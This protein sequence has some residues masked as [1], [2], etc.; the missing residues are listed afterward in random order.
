MLGINLGDRTMKNIALAG[1]ILA[2]IA[3]VLCAGEPPS[4]FE[5]IAHARSTKKVPF[6]VVDAATGKKQI[7]FKSAV[8]ELNRKVSIDPAKTAVVVCDMW[9]DHWCKAAAARCD[10]LAK[11]AD[12]V[13]KACRD[14][15]MTIIH[16]P[17]DCTG[18]YKDH[19]AR[20]RM[21]MVPKTDP[22]QAREL[23]NPPLPVDDSDGGCDDE[24]PAKQ[25][26]AWSRQNAAIAI[27]EDKDYITD[28]GSEVYSLLASRKLGTLLV[29][30]VHTN[31]CVL[32]RTF[33]IKQM[34]KWGQEVYLVRDLTD[35]MYNPKMK[36]FVDHKK[37]TELIIEFI[38]LNWCPTIE[39]K[40]LVGGK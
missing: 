9:D 24:K 39:S 2:A 33:A 20:K 4:K 7:E 14:K 8:E 26:R 36:P 38:E 34:V 30:G 16:C 25:Y 17:S 32:N 23:P 40:G 1:T 27:D 21:L 18:F 5:V 3:T 37:G 22:P 29:M 13:L 19:P 11:S 6:E 10:E 31:M 28:S 35:A 15:G 12:P